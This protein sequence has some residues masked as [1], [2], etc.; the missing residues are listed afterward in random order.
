MP[1]IDKPTRE[2]N[3]SAI[4]IDNILINKI[5]DQIWSGNIVSDI[6]DHYSQFCVKTL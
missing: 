4:L 6:S 1:S 3:N 5:E 2:Y